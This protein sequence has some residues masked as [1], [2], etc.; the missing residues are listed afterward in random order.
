M[1]GYGHALTIDAAQ[2]LTSE[3]HINALPRGSAGI[4]SFKGYVAESRSRGATWTLVS[5]AAVHEAEKRSRALGDASPVT[6]ED[7]WKRVAAD[8]ATKNYKP[9]ATDLIGTLR[10]HRE[11]AVDTLLTLGLRA[12]SNDGK[13]KELGRDL[14]QVIRAKVVQEQVDPEIVALN[15]AIKEN[16]KRLDALSKRAASFLQE[17]QAETQEQQRKLAEARQRNEATPSPSARR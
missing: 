4:S 14:R 11:Q 13:S 3:E 6:T 16:G 10:R 17:M 2:G 12:E 9:L 1:L 15:A 8:M 5:G 7:I